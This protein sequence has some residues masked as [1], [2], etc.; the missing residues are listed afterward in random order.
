MGRNT[1]IS[2]D[3]IRRVALLGGNPPPQFVLSQAGLLQ[4]LVEMRRI[5]GERLV[6][7]K[8][9][10]LPSGRFLFH[11]EVGPANA[12]THDAVVTDIHSEELPIF[13]GTKSQ[14]DVVLEDV[15]S[16]ADRCL[17]VFGADSDHAAL[18]WDAVE[19][20]NALLGDEAAWSRLSPFFN[21][22][23]EAKQ[24][25]SPFLA[26][27]IGAISYRQNDPRFVTDWST[28]TV[29][30]RFLESEFRRMQEQGIELRACALPHSAFVV[31]PHVFLDGE[32]SRV[33][34]VGRQVQASADALQL[35]VRENL[36]L[37]SDPLP[38]D[39]DSY[40][41]AAVPQRPIPGCRGVHRMM[42]KKSLMETVFEDMDIDRTISEFLREDLWPDVLIVETEVEQLRETKMTRW[43]LDELDQ[44]SL[45]GLWGRAGRQFARFDEMTVL[46]LELIDKYELDPTDPFVALAR[47]AKVGPSRW[48]RRRV[49]S[50]MALVTRSA[51]PRLTGN[52]QAPL[53]FAVQK[54]SSVAAML[55][56]NEERFTNPDDRKIAREFW[57]ELAGLATTVS[58]DF[59]VSHPIDT[60]LTQVV[61]TEVAMRS[62]GRNLAPEV[63]RDAEKGRALLQRHEEL[64][65]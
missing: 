55:M 44:V 62:A 43:G 25:N 11:G 21:K 53:M 46:A 41:E 58:G 31:R 56:R 52:P 39:G 50:E 47:G 9:E 13:N 40:D 28:S 32:D 63:Y 65:L 34:D 16:G 49:G 2:A 14:V 7:L 37:I 33:D 20:S 4:H 1:D 30:R 22:V 10:P 29:G 57:W 5:H 23:R 18:Q 45:D 24:K 64:Q 8:L 27:L 59:D 60:T 38:L 36:V 35:Y 17:H 61:S 12:G 48:G 54:F 6:R 42:Y 3:E 51:D 15:R 19:L 26:P